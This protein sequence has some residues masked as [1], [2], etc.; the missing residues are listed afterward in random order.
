VKYQDVFK[1]D[2][3][4]NIHVRWTMRWGGTMEGMIMQWWQPVGLPEENADK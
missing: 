2:R 1:R 4:A 3:Q